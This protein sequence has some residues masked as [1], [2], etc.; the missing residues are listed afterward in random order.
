VSSDELIEVVNRSTH[1]GLVPEGLMRGQRPKEW[2]S[3][4]SV[5]LLRRRGKTRTV[6]RSDSSNGVLVVTRIIWGCCPW[7]ID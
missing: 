2:P 3:G 6:E 1:V 4:R 7:I 5:F